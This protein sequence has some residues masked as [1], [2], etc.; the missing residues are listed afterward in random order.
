MNVRRHHR[1]QRFVDQAMALNST[2]VSERIGNNLDFKMSSAILRTG[3][4]G[5]QMALVLDDKR[6]GREGFAQ[7]GFDPCGSVFGHGRTRLNGFTTTF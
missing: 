2:A 6:V 1:S 5:M 7:L 3:M 4:A